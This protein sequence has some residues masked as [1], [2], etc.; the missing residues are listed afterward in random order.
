MSAYT[1]WR[2]KYPIPKGSRDLLEDLGPA[3]LKN[4]RDKKFSDNI[5]DELYAKLLDARKA[6]IKEK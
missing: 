2:G 3:R 1:I 4:D 5:F 6:Q